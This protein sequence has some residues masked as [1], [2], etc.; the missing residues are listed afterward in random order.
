[1]ACE[2]FSCDCMFWDC[3]G[4]GLTRQPMGP[5]VNTVAISTATGMNHVVS[6]SFSSRCTKTSADPIR[7]LCIRTALPLTLSL[8]SRFVSSA[9]LMIGPSPRA[10]GFVKDFSCD[11][12]LWNERGGK[13]APVGPQ[14]DTATI[15]TVLSSHR[16]DSGSLSSRRCVFRRTHT[17]A[18]SIRLRC[19]RLALSLDSLLALTIRAQRK[20]YGWWYTLCPMA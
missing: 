15:R 13:L 6:G 2:G 14:V 16:A 20:T 12:M 11:Y 1:M 10:Q 9:R 3:R 4:G 7:I 19:I 5:T 17:S 8:P 18:D